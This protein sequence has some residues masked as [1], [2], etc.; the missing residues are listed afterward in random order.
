MLMLC[1]AALALLIVAKPFGGN[2]TDRISILLEVPY[3]GQGVAPGTAMVMH[4][5]KVGEVRAISSQSS[6]G[7][8]MNVDLDSASASGLTDSLGVDFRPTNYFGVT[9]INLVPGAGGQALRDG[10][11]ITAEPQGNSTL[12]ALLYRLGEITGGVVTPQLVRV[13]DRA[14]RYT[15]GLNPLI[16]T[17]LTAA[18]AV[19][20]VQTVST[21]QLLRNA[22]GISVAFPQ[23]VDAATAAGYQ[24]NQNSGFVTFN[25]SAEGA[26]PN[27]DYVDTTAAVGER[28]TA[29][30]WE[31]RSMATL[32]LIANSFFGALGKV[33]SSHPSELIPAVEL[34]KTLTDVVPGLVTPD[35]VASDLVELRTRLEKLYAGS[36]EQRALQVQIVLDSLPGVAT[37]IDVM[38]RP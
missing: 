27:Q 15:D 29:E 34:V 12:Q 32:D 25:T 19:A 26:L 4:G 20:N 37:P 21:A 28:Q 38:G 6:G 14:T 22:T 3:V 23:F 1:L 11:R 36:P 7:V 10:T 18:D 31:K 30:Y 17:L 9:G 13:V 5:V 33:L 8:R 16:E 35:N 2:R 24:F